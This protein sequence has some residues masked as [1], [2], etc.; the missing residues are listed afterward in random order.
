MDLTDEQWQVVK[1][2]IWVIL[3]SSD[4]LPVRSE[5]SIHR[6]KKA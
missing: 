4:R 2:L 6:G 1:P 5:A 3:G